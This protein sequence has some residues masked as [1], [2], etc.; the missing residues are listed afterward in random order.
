AVVGWTLR[1]YFPRETVCLVAG[2]RD[3]GKSQFA[4]W[5]CAAVSNGLG[6]TPS[7]AETQARKM[8]ALWNTR[9]DTVEQCQARLKAAGADLSLVWLTDEDW[10]LPSDA[11]RIK[12]R[13]EQHQREGNPI[14]LLVLDSLQAHFK[15]P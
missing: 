13:L 12:A 11:G 8:V 10:T 2:K 15:N 5:L 9:E 7:G 3:L 6:V 14:D 1:G 4:A